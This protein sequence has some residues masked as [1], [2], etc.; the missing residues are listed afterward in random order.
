[1]VGSLKQENCSPVRP[2]YKITRVKRAEGMTQAVE[3]LPGKQETLSST[4]N[5]IK[6]KK[7]KESHSNL[8]ISVDKAEYI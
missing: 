5:T 2:I 6:K 1:M 8:L 4:P 7:K 3:C